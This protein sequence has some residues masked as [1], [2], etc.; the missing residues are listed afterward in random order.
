MGA[1]CIR[2]RVVLGKNLGLFCVGRCG[3]VEICL[4]GVERVFYECGV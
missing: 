3:G 2:D 1:G 4:F